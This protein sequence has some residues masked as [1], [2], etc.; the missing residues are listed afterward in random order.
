VLVCILVHVCVSVKMLARKCH[1]ALV[2]R[3]LVTLF[4]LFLWYLLFL[5]GGRLLG[6]LKEFIYVCTVLLRNGGVCNC[7]SVLF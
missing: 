4:W 2:L 1:L 6:V 7:V 3:V 5:C